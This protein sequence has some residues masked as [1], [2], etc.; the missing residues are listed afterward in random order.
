MALRFAR[1]TRRRSELGMAITTQESWVERESP[2][3]V[4]VPDYMREVVET[5]A[6]LAREDKRVDK[7]SRRLAAPADFPRWKTWCRMP[8]AAR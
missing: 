2:V 3:D 7:R 6:F 1:T 4:R 8:S 5:L